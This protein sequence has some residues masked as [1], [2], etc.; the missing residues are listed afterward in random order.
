MGKSNAKHIVNLEKKIARLKQDKE[1]LTAI[2]AV[3]MADVRRRL[4]PE[5]SEIISELKLSDK[6]RG[7]DST[8][9]KWEFPETAINISRYGGFR[10]PEIIATLQECLAL[11]IGEIET[12][13]QEIRN[14]D[15]G[16]R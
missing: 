6:S 12:L 8:S 7:Y 11:A 3:Y 9:D 10:Q 2:L 4:E 15:K 1:S 16:E 5:L 13:R 14:G